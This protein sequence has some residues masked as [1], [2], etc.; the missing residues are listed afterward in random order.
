MRD[1]CV[2]CQIANGEKKTHMIYEDELICSFLDLDP[3]NPGHI[4]I[5]PKKHYLDLDELDEPTLLAIIMHTRNLVEVLK[6]AF[7]PGGYSIM[8]N[9]GEFNDVGHFHMHVFPR[10]NGDGFGWTY[11]EVGE[12]RMSNEKA[13]G[14]IL[15]QLKK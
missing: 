11:G 1:D 10:Y 13:L 15:N 14:I 4:L 3:I 8:Q 12:D 6:K 9:G 5:I 2:F 7:I